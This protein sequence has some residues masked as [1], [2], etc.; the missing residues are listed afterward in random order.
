MLKVRGSLLGEAV[1]FFLP[2][3]TN[4]EADELIFNHTMPVNSK[5]LLLTKKKKTHKHRLEK[6]SIK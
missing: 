6:F 2:F 4:F 1:F 3:N 5:L